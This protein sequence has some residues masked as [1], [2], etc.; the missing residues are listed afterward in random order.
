MTE[1]ITKDALISP[2]EAYR[3]WLTREWDAGAEKLPFVMLNPSTA[4]ASLDDP[5][6]RR[7]MSFAR[8]EAYGGIVVMNLFALRATDPA[9]LKGAAD[10]LGPDNDGH[11]AALFEYAQARQ[12]PI[13]AA[14]GVH[15][16]L[17]GRAAA[18]KAVASIAGARLVC[19]GHT[20][21]GHPKHPLYI[22]G[23]QPLQ[24]VAA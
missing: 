20:K 7:C 4:D 16:V 22:A 12:L 14:W 1:I 21:S 2:C 15:G 6:I 11:L 8:R 18:V 13:V 10:P 19:F 23:D 9:A 3:Y 5:T 17:N 24:E